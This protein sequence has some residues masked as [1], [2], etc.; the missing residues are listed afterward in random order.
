MIFKVRTGSHLYGLAAKD[1]DTDFLSVFIPH[2]RDL[3]GLHPLEYL[4]KSTKKTETARRNTKNDVDDKSFSL[5]RFIKLLLR[6]NPNIIEV[7]FAD[8]SNV[9]VCEPEAM[10]LINNH[11]K[12]VSQVVRETFTGYAYSQKK[13]LVVKKERFISLQK[14]LDYLEN[15]LFTLDAE[16][17]G[18]AGRRTAEDIIVLVKNKQY[19]REISE[20]E[21]GI[22]N[23]LLKYY[24]G[25]KQNCESFHKG[26]DVAMI[27]RK[28][29][30]EY[31]N[32]GWRVRTESFNKVGYDTK[33]AYHLIRLLFEGWQLL[34]TGQITY[35]IRGSAKKQILRI[36]NQ[37]VSFDELL[38][39][40]D[41]WHE[42]I[43]SV[44]STL[45]EKPDYEWANTY[46]IR[47]LKKSIINENP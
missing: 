27:Y 16:Q 5:T 8:K 20:K 26:M 17:H 2:S 10:E 41:I 30:N 28:I 9:L 32:Y 24:K 4:D 25:Q 15:Q 39:M 31:E 22:L 33:F 35:P 38:E 3:L 18:K 23:R 12:I 34:S 47:I 46:L 6:N 14:G 21:A 44:T 37:E 45:P 7:L 13:K 42:K 1:S 19:Y 36:R 40:Y 11:D 29:R 43:Q